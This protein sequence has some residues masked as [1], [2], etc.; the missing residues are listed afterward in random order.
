[1]YWSM[2]PHGMPTNSRS[3]V[4]HSI[5]SFRGSSARP[6][7]NASAEETSSAAE[8][9]RP[10]PSGTVLRINADDPAAKALMARYG[11]RLLPTFLS[12]DADGHEVERLVGEQTHERLSLAV[13]DI[14][15]RACNAL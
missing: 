8:E 5:A 2:M 6:L 10:E 4:W 1:M 3:A 12:I 9:L 13:G 15:G 7:R 14:H 11:V